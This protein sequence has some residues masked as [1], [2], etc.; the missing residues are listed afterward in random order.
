[1]CVQESLTQTM[2]K[3][4]G[5]LP[6]YHKPDIITLITSYME[7]TQATGKENRAG[8]FRAGEADKK[9]SSRTGTGRYMYM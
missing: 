6:D 9:H 5:V 3:F 4:A 8:K 1:M 2:G 7:P